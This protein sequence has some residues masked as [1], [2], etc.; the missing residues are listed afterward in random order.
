VQE[1]IARLEALAKNRWKGPSDDQPNHA[2]PG[3]ARGLNGPA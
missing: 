2:P 1:R 3:T